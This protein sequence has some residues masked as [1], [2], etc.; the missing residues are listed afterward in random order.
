MSGWHHPT[1][2]H[3]SCTA[4]IQLNFIHCS[5]GIDHGAGHPLLLSHHAKAPNYRKNKGFKDFANYSRWPKVAGAMI[6][7]VLCGKELG[8]T[9]EVGGKSKFPLHVMPC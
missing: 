7:A 2:Q 9:V 3:L 1:K 6:E 8:A 5:L 4:I